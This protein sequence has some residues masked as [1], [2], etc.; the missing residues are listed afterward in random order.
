[1]P[2]SLNEGR[3]VQDPE[4]VSWTEAVKHQRAFHANE[5][6]V[7][8]MYAELDAITEEIEVVEEKLETAGVEVKPS[9]EL[10]RIEIGKEQDALIASMADRMESM[11]QQQ[12]D[13]QMA[14]VATL[15]QIGLRDPVFNVQAP[16]V[17][18]EPANVTVEAA[19]P[20]EI[21]VHVPEQPAPNVT[22]SPEF[23][24]P[25]AETKK[26]VTFVRDFGGRL[27]SAEITE[28]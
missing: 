14:L 25:Q 22:V 21:N 16:N 11:Q 10:V 23:V 20:A 13:L 17:N 12:A 3:I 15:Q 5:S 7:A 27:E 9:G 2:W 6:R 4:G 8:A 1:M 26:T 18:I 19:P 28:E 24:I